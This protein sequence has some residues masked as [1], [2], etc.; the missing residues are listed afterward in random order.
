MAS[1]TGYEQLQARLHAV[2]GSGS[3]SLMNQLGLAVVREAK[4]RVP[5]RTGNLGRSIAVMAH[6]A[7]SVTVSARANYA[8]FVELGTRAHEIT[9][10]AKRA[11]R[12]A[13]SPSG[14]RLSGAPRSGAAVVFA[15]RVHHPGTKPEPFLI[16]GAKAAVQKVAGQ[17][18]VDAWNEAA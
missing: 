14:R 3:A 11:L 5:R 1:V 9:P 7:T 8:A 16:P 13:A 15:T 17:T 4:L 6:S 18:V 12:W 10:N 2:G